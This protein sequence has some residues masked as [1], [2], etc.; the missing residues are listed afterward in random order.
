MSVSD[1][2]TRLHDVPGIEN[3]TMQNLAGRQVYSLG[4][5]VIGLDPNASDAEIENAIRA[6]VASPSI[7][8][9]PLEGASVALLPNVA[10]APSQ[11]IPRGKAMSVTGAA[12]AGMSLKQMMADKKAKLAAA[13][14]KLSANF[15]KLDQATA[16][17]DSLG[18]DV[19]SEADDLLASIGQFKNDLGA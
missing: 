10:P 5:K 9:I 15:G 19:G 3:L 4:G 12:H 14:D 6:A 11:S 18:D 2:K 7:A 17:L 8:L 1:L 16:A 13:H